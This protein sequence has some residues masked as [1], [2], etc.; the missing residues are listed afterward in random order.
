MRR[1]GE[2]EETAHAGVMGAGGATKKKWKEN[3]HK[4]KKKRSQVGFRRTFCSTFLV[5]D[6]AN[7]VDMARIGGSEGVDGTDVEKQLGQ[8]ETPRD[9]KRTRRWQTFFFS[10]FR[11]SAPIHFASDG[12]ASLISFSVYDRFILL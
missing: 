6:D 2:R 12:L 1:R 3:Q 10:F 7:D 8:V 9:P 4:E 5:A 11:L